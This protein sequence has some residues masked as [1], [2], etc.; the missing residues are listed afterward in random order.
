M[1]DLNKST[2]KNKE[3][4][5]YLRAW[6]VSATMGYGHQRAVYPLKTIAEGNIISVGSGQ[7]PSKAEEKLWKRVLGAY[8]FMSRAR[9][10]PFIGKM[11]FSLLDSLLR[12]PSYYP[13]R[14]LSNSTF[15]VD[16][17]Q[18]SIKKGL[19]SNM[20][21]KIGTKNIP[22]VTSFYAS[23]IAADMKGFHNVYCIICDADLNRVWVAK[24]PWES[25]I[26][27]FAPC[28][29][30][31]QRLRAYGVPDERIFITGFPLP[32]ELLGDEKLSVL[33]SNLGK[34]LRRLD[35][36]NIFWQRHG[37][38]VEYFLG[39]ENCIKNTE[40][41]L[42]ITYAVGGAG[43]LKEIGGKIAESL[44]ELIQ[45]GSVKLNLVAGT[46]ETVR[47]Y[48]VS[49]KRKICNDN[50]KINIIYSASM[51]EYFDLFNTA[52]NDTDILWTK[53]SELSFYTALGIPVIMTPPIGSQEKFNRKWL[54]EIQA[55]IKQVNPDY[56]NQWL[57]DYWN[58]GILAEA[59]WSGFLKARKKGTFKIMEILQTGEMKQEQSPVLR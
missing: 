48:F 59:A 8:E 56:T 4:S 35:P 47:D 42:T 31:A 11:I 20:L 12:I 25:S 19:C 24:A 3:N 32:I 55:G 49:V 51:H 16:L 6:V 46:K 15:Q 38:N 50:D 7:P 13:M 41:K 30:A 54:Y 1:E 5:E 21:D 58:K 36:Q 28:G 23:A 14:N 10:I 52:L 18:S 22:L 34:R 9:G 26:Y 37:V 43:A 44:K 57:I 39:Q 40:L 29:K 2:D 27:Y 17:L 45:N 53:P 33:K